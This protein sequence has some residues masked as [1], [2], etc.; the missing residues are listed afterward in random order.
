MG[1][2]VKAISQRTSLTCLIETFELSNHWKLWFSSRSFPP[3]SLSLSLSLVL[4]W[5]L[6]FTEVWYLICKVYGK[7]LVDFFQ[8]EEVAHS[9]NIYPHEVSFT[10]GY[11]AWSPFL[12]TLWWTTVPKNFLAV[13]GLR[14]TVTFTFLIDM[15]IF[16][17][18]KNW[19]IWKENN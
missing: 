10:H 14:F 9:T 15:L 7:P 3:P 18:S 13:Y 1:H 17:N 11:L 6:W 19:N 12:K 16:L 4:L 5:L 2:Y 8:I